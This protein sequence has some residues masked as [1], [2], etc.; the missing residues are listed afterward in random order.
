[1]EDKVGGSVSISRRHLESMSRLARISLGVVLES[2]QMFTKDGLE[3]NERKQRSLKTGIPDLREKRDASVLYLSKHSIRVGD[4]GVRRQSLRLAQKQRTAFLLFPQLIRSLG[5][6]VGL[7]TKTQNG[8]TSVT[9]PL[10][11]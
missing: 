7:S 5:V 10:N 3:V 1:M 4:Q 11:P 2:L 8:I 9:W 6:C